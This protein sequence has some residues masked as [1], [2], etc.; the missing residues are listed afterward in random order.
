VVNAFQAEYPAVRVQI[1]VTEPVVDQIAEGV[2][3]DTGTSATEAR[4]AVPQG[5]DRRAPP[6]HGRR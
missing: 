3:I 4:K 5:Y 2:L 6:L 1:F